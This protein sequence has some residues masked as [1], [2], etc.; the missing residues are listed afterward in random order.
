MSNLHW[1]VAVDCA[2]QNSIPTSTDVAPATGPVPGRIAQ[3]PSTWVPAT[4]CAWLPRAP[5]VM[6]CVNTVTVGMPAPPRLSCTLAWS[7]SA[8]S[9]KKTV[10]SVPPPY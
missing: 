7:S 1:N 10:I 4:F 9:S 2:Y 5:V 6:I 8:G 3:A